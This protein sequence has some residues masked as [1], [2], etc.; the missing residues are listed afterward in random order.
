MPALPIDLNQIVITA[1]R[2]EAR[3]DASP[4]SVMIFDHSLIKRLDEPGIGGLIR[5]S[6]SAAV[7]SSG[8]SGSL[9]EVRIRGAEANHTL[10]YVDGI[11]L[12][13]PASGGT[14]R[15]ELLNADVAS[16]IEIVRGPQS[17]LWGSDAIGGVIAVN[18][19]DEPSGYRAGIEAGSFGFRRAS[20]GGAFASGPFALAIGV[21][22]Q[23]ASGIDSFGSPGGDRDGFRN[24]S[25]RVRGGVSITPALRLGFAGL[26]LRGKSEFDGYNLT[27]FV[28][29]DTLDISRNRLNAGRAWLEFGTDRSAWR[30]HVGVTVLG[31]SN[32][33]LLDDLPINQTW[34]KRALVDAQVQ[35]SLTTGAIGHQFVLAAETEREGY[36]TQDF[37]YGGFSDQDRKRRRQAL[38]AEWRA[39][40]K[41]FVTDVAARQDF[42]SGFK[43]STS[44]RASALTPIG[45]G[46]SITAAYASGIAQPTFVEQFGFFP[47]TF[48]GNGALKPESSSGF[49]ASLRYRSGQLG[50]AL[51]VYRQRLKDE[52][53]DVYDP[54]TGLDTSVN[55]ADDSKRSGLEAEAFATVATWLNLRANYS[56]LRATQPPSS[57]SGRLTEARRPR[58]SGAVIAEG[59]TG[60]W[61]YGGSVAYVAPRRDNQDNFPYAEVTLGRY[62]LADARVAYAVRPGLEAFVRG[63]NLFDARYQD[64]AGYNTEGRGIFAGISLRADR[65]SSP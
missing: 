1:S 2:I 4:A 58:H 46:F 47:G 8:P 35:R 43:D 23:R 44:L 38:T 9:T 54:V 6:P 10:F 39:T 49:E 26:L 12:N 5:L 34:G 48:V 14:P 11:K 56:Y 61:S 31:S 24:F 50:G 3:E 32:R 65:R 36:R 21:G 45:G 29:E 42:F 20:A 55:R 33:N 28:H 16:R 53:V 27:T 51:T 57:G 18:G 64:A 52:I 25:G 22:L 13:D 7:A 41:G 60:R 37:Y 62:W 30:G 40:M 59:S 19:V 15:F 63:S 17:A